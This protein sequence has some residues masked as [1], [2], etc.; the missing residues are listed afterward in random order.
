M[1]D[2][3]RRLVAPPVFEGDEDKTRIAG[4]LNTILLSVAVFA[5]QVGIVLPFVS[6]Q[7]GLG[8]GAPPAAVLICLGGLFLLRRG[9]VGVASLLA[10]ALLWAGYTALLIVGGG[11]NSPF[12]IGILVAL[13]MAALLFSGRAIWTLFGLSAVTLIGIFAAG[14]AG[15]LPQPIFPV[16]PLS[17]LVVVAANLAAAAV[18]LYL[19]ARGL[20]QELARSRRLAA[21]LEGQRKRLE[22][23]VQERTRDLARRSQYLQAA[24]AVAR[25]AAAVLNLDLLLSQ[26]AAL[27]SERFG[28]YHTGIFILDPA[29][30]WAVLQA[31]SSDGGRRM[32]AR[33]HQ[34]KVGQTGMVGMTAALGRPHI[35][36]DVGA[37]AVFFD[38]PD[39]P[40]TRSEAALPLRARGEVIGVLDVQSAE[41]AAFSQEDVTVLQT[42]ADQVAVAI[43][44]ARLFRQAEQGLEAER[45]AYGE[46]SRQAWAEMV[47]ARPDLGYH[48]RDGKVERVGSDPQ[49]SPSPDPAVLQRDFP[50]LPAI[51]LP[52]EYRGQALGTIVA[53][54]PAGSGEWTPEETALLG[55]LAEQLSV[56]LDSARLYQATQRRAAQ[57]R[58]VG[59]VTARMRQTLDV[60]AVLRTAAQEMR[61]A[62]GLSQI[63]VRLT[64]PGQAG[65]EAP[66]PP[67]YG[68]TLDL[69]SSGG[70]V[71]P[72][73]G[74]KVPPEDGGKEKTR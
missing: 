60:D 61:Q 46:F 55:T 58:L 62:L 45:Q 68:G 34:L 26:V 59:D 57:E 19:S 43:D 27:V 40:D 73:D 74:G 70:K 17:G 15:L 28:F 5:F 16:T 44:N 66:I 29:R 36:L 41:P 18:M 63:A 14:E 52:I 12:S 53:H 48:Y 4:L 69:T 33:R 7:S 64:S 20:S 2:W 23:T 22:V 1:I 65:R 37:D 67:E 49:A 32:L 13:L 71:S 38:N 8:L 3:I 72:E 9:Y 24:G 31:V 21:E 10:V 35:A 11:I 51:S 25:E 56:A 47:R 42:L 6:P 54:K 39:L 30:E 50:G